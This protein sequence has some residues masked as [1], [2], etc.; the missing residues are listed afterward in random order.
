MQAY[1]S[2]I[3]R[4]CT[5]STK[6]YHSTR[7]SPRFDLYNN[8]NNNNN[9]TIEL[10]TN[11]FTNTF[12]EDIARYRCKHANDT[13]CYCC[14]ILTAIRILVLRIMGARGVYSAWGTS[15]L[16]SSQHC[17]GGKDCRPFQCHSYDM[18]P[19]HSLKGVAR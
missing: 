12:A 13:Q 10:A 9:H 19:I 1:H 18:I 14:A 5:I 11:L 6:D 8:N 16:G 15:Q 17:A 7:Q 2:S 4:P 3:L